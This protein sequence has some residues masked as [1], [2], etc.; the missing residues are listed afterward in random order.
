MLDGL[1]IEITYLSA[2][3]NWLDCSGWMAAITNLE[4]AKGDVAKSFFTWFQ[5][6]ENEVYPSSNIMGIRSTA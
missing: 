5:S 1:H 3:G 6:F 2:L 4:I